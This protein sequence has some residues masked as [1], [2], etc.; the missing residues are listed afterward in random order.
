M[1][2][3]Y[4]C[5]LWGMANPTLEAN[6]RQ[7][8]EAGFDGVEMAA[9]DEEGKRRD[10]RS[11]L[12]DLELALIVIQ[13]TRGVT[14]KEHSQSFAELLERGIAMAPLFINSHTGKDFFTKR[15][16][17]ALIKKAQKL[18]QERGI[19]VYHEIHRTRAPFTTNRALALLDALPA[20][21][22]TAD[23]SHWCV[24]HESFLEDQPEAMARA[25]ERT[26]H[27]HARVGYPEGA[28]VPDPRAPEWQP[29]VDIHV[30]WWQ[31]VVDAR[32][33]EGLALLTISTEFGPPPYL[34][35]LPYTRQPIANLWEINL[36][37]RDY[38]KKTLVV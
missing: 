35:T 29:A 11:L 38:L 5:S 7:I 20:L 23:F 14:P 10:L 15:E 36:W 2:I 9:P 25:I 8:K 18:A 1:K 16:N 12:D 32:K 28:Q 30:A 19:T 4:F 21:Q 24:V 6:L 33:K 22:L 3:K 13:H 37:M 17:L 34:Q 26:Y 31:Q 27:I